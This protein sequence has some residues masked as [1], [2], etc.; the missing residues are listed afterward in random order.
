MKFKEIYNTYTYFPKKKHV[1]KILKYNVNN[2][3]IYIFIYFL[4]AKSSANA[5]L[6]M[7]ERVIDS[8]GG[9]KVRKKY[10]GTVAILFF[11]TT[12]IEITSKIMLQLHDS[13]KYV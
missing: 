9:K 13:F 3:N 7:Y 4:P 11:L 6:G 5:S 1:L 12:P 2:P 8:E 10:P